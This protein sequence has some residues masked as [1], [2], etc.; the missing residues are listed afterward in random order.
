MRLSSFSI[1]LVALLFLTP[2]ASQPSPPAPNLAALDAI[3]TQTAAAI[4]DW[5]S[6]AR[7]QVYLTIAAILFGGLVTVLQPWS[8]KTWC[9][10]VT[11]TLGLSIAIVTGVTSKAFPVDYRLYQRSALQ[12]HAKMRG[13]QADILQLKA[14]PPP[15]DE[16]ELKRDFTERLK[17]IGDIEGKLSGDDKTAGLL[18]DLGGVVY[19][20]SS[21]L[22]AWVTKPP[23]SPSSVYFVGTGQGRYFSEAKANSLNHALGQAATYLTS[24]SPSVDRDAALEFARSSTSVDDT[25]FTFDDRKQSYRYYTLTRLDK[26]LAS[27]GAVRALAAP[28]VERWPVK[29]SL[30]D[31]A[32]PNRESAIALSDLLALGLPPGIAHNDRRFQS[33]RIPSFGNLF[34]VSEGDILTTTGWLWLVASETDGDYHIQISNSR[35]SGDHCLVVEIPNPSPLFT[36]DVSLRPVFQTARAFVRD[37]L[38]AGREP[39]EA[40]TVMQH[41]AFVRVTGQLFLDTGAIGNA[42]RGKKGMK[43]ATLWELHPVTAIALAPSPTR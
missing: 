4:S 31:G 33:A 40:G 2:A 18:P 42:P 19:A 20:Q 14:G 5:E 39:G 12:A 27:A 25:A 26:A 8:A 3:V 32:N 43:A 30:R 24:T 21:V 28:E 16:R 34:N 23:A 37:K 29:T 1:L 41:P 38:L 7:A 36:S 9:K 22:P 11:A 17:A 35:E 13:M 6:A 10:G 15:D